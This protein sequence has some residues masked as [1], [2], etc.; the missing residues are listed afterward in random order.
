VLDGNPDYDPLGLL[1]PAIASFFTDRVNARFA[2]KSRR[3]ESA[4]ALAANPRAI[5]TDVEVPT[6]A[7]AYPYL[8]VTIRQALAQLG[9]EALLAEIAYTTI[10]E[11]TAPELL[12]IPVCDGIS[13][14]DGRVTQIGEL[15]SVFEDYLLDPT[16]SIQDLIESERV[17]E[18]V[19]EPE[20]TPA[21]A[22]ALYDLLG[23]AIWLGQDEQELRVHR[24]DE[25]DL[26]G[27]FSPLDYKAQTV[28]GDEALLPQPDESVRNRATD[29]LL[30]ALAMSDKRGTHLTPDAKILGVIPYYEAEE[31]LEAAIDSL[32]KQS[33]PLQGIV[34]IDDCSS[35]PPTETL[36]KFPEVT[37][38]RSEENSGPFRLIQEVID[39][40]GY[41]AYLFQDSDDWSAPNRLDVLLE[42]TTRSG[43]ELVGSQGHR[44][45]MDEGEVVPYQHPIDPEL[46]FQ[47]TPRSKPVHHPTS[48]V[49]RDLIQRTGGF[50]TGLRFSGDTEFLRRAATVG[51]I[52]NTPEF[53]YV[54][55]TRADSLTGSEETGNHTAVRRDLWAIQHPR[56]EWIAVR[57]LAGLGTILA[58]MAVTSPAKLTHLSGPALLGVNGEAWPKGS[59]VAPVLTTP[60]KAPARRKGAASPPRPV[61]VI[62]APRSGTSILALS[63][64]QLPS[65]K[66]VLDP[67]WLSNLSSALHVAFSA[68]E[69]AETVD[70]LLMQQIDTEQFAAH[71]GAAAHE[72]LLQGIN[73]AISAPF[74]N[75]QQKL[76]RSRV[77]HARTR[78]LAE[79]AALAERGF[80]LYRLF[81][82]AKFIHVIRDPDEVAAAHQKDRRGLYRSRFVYMDEEQAYDRWIEV[83]RAARDLEVALGSEKV[84][85]VD[86]AAMFADPDAT[87]RSVLEFIGEPFDPVVLRPFA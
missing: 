67:G 82:H 61:F 81:P 55:R 5:A 26:R 56:A 9:P 29:P 32:L 43:R 33:R 62:G 28:L 27:A 72:L 38:L 50:C 85:R 87:V 18:L 54:Y 4:I 68:T 35:T 21:G 80:D 14:R 24:R 16:S 30:D 58:P 15:R 17:A 19:A 71:F 36:A 1:R 79:G 3:T 42:L 78:V 76:L 70:D 46:S 83:V 31:Y 39:N 7:H 23:A 84:M 51:R 64:A 8:D 2:D 69:E 65:F 11:R 25:M 12:S 73:P 45:I 60:K 66:L 44:L 22:K 59:G 53:I 13:D 47:N 20:P 40:T 52:A 10:M 6:I 77:K 41:D 57:A 86:R 49:T 75:E 63:I 34:V 37:L 74:E 48:L